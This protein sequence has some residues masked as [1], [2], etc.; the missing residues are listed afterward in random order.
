MWNIHA[1][2]LEGKISCMHH[3]DA[4]WSKNEKM[5]SYQIINHTTDRQPFPTQQIWFDIYQFLCLHIHLFSCQDHTLLPLIYIKQN[6]IIFGKS[7]SHQELSDIKLYIYIE[8]RGS[9]REWER[10][11]GEGKSTLLWQDQS[12]ERSMEPRRRH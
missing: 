3:K 8:E 4:K 7:E 11:N 12:E 6:Q 1:S 10:E 2:V 5:E 9:E